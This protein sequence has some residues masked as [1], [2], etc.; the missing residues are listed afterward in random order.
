MT[1]PG[2]TLGNTLS[3]LICSLIQ[4]VLVLIRIITVFKDW[5]NAHWKHIFSSRD[6]EHITIMGQVSTETWYYY[7]HQNDRWS[8]RLLVAVVMLCDT[9][10]QALIMHIAAKRSMNLTAALVQGQLPGVQ[11]LEING[12]KWIV[13]PVDTDQL[14]LMMAE[15][16]FGVSS[17]VHNG[18]FIEIETTL[19]GL[20]V[21]GF[22]L[23]AT[24]DTYISGLVIFL[25]NTSRT[26]FRRSDTIINRLANVR[27]NS[28]PFSGYEESSSDLLTFLVY[29]NSLLANLNIRTIIHKEEAQGIYGDNLY[30]WPV[31]PQTNTTS[32]SNSPTGTTQDSM[33]ASVIDHCE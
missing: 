3:P 22:M 6:Y 31:L 15:T 21:T 19:E 29:T 11:N 12:N 20:M 17:F 9:V 5:C 32:L 8:L 30:S 24:V 10:Q 33:P 26:G 27:A 18:T 7:M 25:L 4:I 2:T 28:T 13:T 1:Q 16:V 14:L 23:S